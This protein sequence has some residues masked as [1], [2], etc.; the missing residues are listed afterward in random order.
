M[1][2]DSSS[3]LSAL[4]FLDP[5]PEEAE[6][7]SFAAAASAAH[8]FSCTFASPLLLA[9]PAMSAPASAAASAPPLTVELVSRS[10]LISLRLSALPV[11]SYPLIV[12]LR[13]VTRRCCSAPPDSGLLD[14]LLVAPSCMILLTIGSGMAAASST[15]TSSALASLSTSRGLAYRTVCVLP[16]FCPLPLPCTV[17]ETTH[18]VLSLPAFSSMP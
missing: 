4:F 18:L 5:P 8:L 14:E 1:G 11:P 15:A 10:S 17:T 16:P 9:A 2:C 3:S 13:N 7:A 12:E 6:K